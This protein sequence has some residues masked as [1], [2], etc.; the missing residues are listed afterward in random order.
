LLSE[1]VVSFECRPSTGAEVTRSRGRRTVEKGSVSRAGPHLGASSCVECLTVAA[2]AHPAT[3]SLGESFERSGLRALR[4]CSLSDFRGGAAV[5]GPFRFSFG[6]L[7]V[8]VDR[9]PQAG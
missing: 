3:I 4:G 6:D 1:E 7:A 5:C 9:R 8:G 2:G